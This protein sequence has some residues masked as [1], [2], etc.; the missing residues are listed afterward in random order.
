MD[1]SETTSNY[2]NSLRKEY[3]RMNKDIREQMNSINVKRN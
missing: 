2:L 1:E 3:D